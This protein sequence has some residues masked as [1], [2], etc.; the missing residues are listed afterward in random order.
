MLAPAK[1]YTRMPQGRIELVERPI[2][3]VAGDHQRGADTNG[4]VAGILTRHA[5]Q[6]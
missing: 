5:T 4:V 6:T 1:R 3:F 2:Y